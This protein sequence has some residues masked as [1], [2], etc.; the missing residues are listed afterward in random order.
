MLS[1]CA[2]HGELNA[3]YFRHIFL[4][5]VLLERIS[6]TRAVLKVFPR[7]VLFH[8]TGHA[9]HQ[10]WWRLQA[11]RGTWPRKRQSQQRFRFC[12][13]GFGSASSSGDFSA[14]KAAALGPC[15]V[16]VQRLAGKHQSI[17]R[18]HFWCFG[19]A[20]GTCDLHGNANG[21]GV[22][23]CLNTQP[24]Q[25]LLHLFWAFLLNILLSFS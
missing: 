9:W 2:R 1:N 14:G 19:S 21:D 6:Q 3:A 11:G 18:F 20:I 23:R 24:P 22:W 4:F 16:V 15:S 5:G 12:W 7:G 8:V 25:S 17:Q 10:F 13:A